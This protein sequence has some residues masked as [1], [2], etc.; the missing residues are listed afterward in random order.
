M[1]RKFFFDIKKY[2]SYLLYASKS[3]L[4]SEVASSKLNWLWWIVEPICMMLIYAFIFGYVL[5]KSEP[6]F[7][8][9]IFIGLTVWNFFNKVFSGSVKIVKNNK[10][11]VSK[12]YLPKYILILQK[13]LVNAFKTL[14]NMAIVAVLMIIYQVPV[15]WNL[16]YIFPV[17]GV[18]FFF[19]FGMSCII[20]HFGVFIED[21]SN[22]TRIVLRLGFYLS[23]I[24]YSIPGLIHGTLGKVLSLG[25]PMAFL[26][27]SARE[28]LLYNMAPS[29]LWLLIWFG[30]SLLL[31][32]AGVRLVYRNE[33]AYIKVI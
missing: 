10:S 15:S 16:L 13:M 23:G 25:N 5:Q 7:P 31:C 12:V 6:Y 24:M 26:I 32:V 19:T 3:E 20:L 22:V 18:L 4:K 27:I 29:G 14:I 28:S 17:F 2:G 9:F 33:N 8:A 11:I 21:L 1:L 30:I